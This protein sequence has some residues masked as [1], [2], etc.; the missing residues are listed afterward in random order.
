MVSRNCLPIL[1]FCLFA[2]FTCVRKVTFVPA[3]QLSV[4][5]YNLDNLYDTMDDTT[6]DDTEFTPS[7]KYAWTVERYSQKLANME[8]VIATIVDGNGP[9]VLGMCEL[10]SRQAVN[11]LFSAKTFEGNYDIVHYDSPDERGIDVALAYNKQKLS[12]LESQ[13]VTVR[14]QRDTSDRTRDILWVRT[15]TRISGDTIDFIV[16]HFPSR[17]E[18]KEQSE[19]DRLDA[20]KACIQIA[21][22][23]CNFSRQNL[24]IMGDFND[25][26]WDQSISGIIGAADARKDEHSELQNLMWQFREEGKGTYRYRDQWNTLDQFMIS[27]ALND[28]K[29]AEYMK[30]SVNITKYDWMVQTGKYHGFPLRTFGGGKW[31]NGYSDHFPIYMKIKI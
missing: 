25:E 19:P 1:V 8:K 4:A 6:H 10:E 20:A 15:L 12:V 21:R 27:S 24:V 29:K 30:G 17:R 11:D 18:G 14:L 23:K 22:E 7:G 16:C 13:K 2:G 26:P 28:G 3:D 31:L 9:D 5:F